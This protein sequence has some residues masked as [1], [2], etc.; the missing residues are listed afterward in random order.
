MVSRTKSYMKMYSVTLRTVVVLLQGQKYYQ[1]HIL[2]LLVVLQDIF[3]AG[4]LH[5]LLH[6][7]T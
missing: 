2:W 1:L 6:L 3:E 7:V 4:R 5:V